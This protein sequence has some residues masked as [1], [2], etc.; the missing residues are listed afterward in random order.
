[1]TKEQVIDVTA[2]LRE[3]N[4][5]QPITV[6]FKGR[7]REVHFFHRGTAEL[8]SDALRGVSEN[9][10]MKR[11]KTRE[12][13][14]LAIVLADLHG[15]SW[16]RFRSL[17]R[18]LWRK[19]LEHSRYSDVEAVALLN[20]ARERIQNGKHLEALGAILLAQMQALIAT[21]TVSREQLSEVL[22]QTTKGE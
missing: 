11:L 7:P 18:W 14:L 2:Q 17:K 13:R 20:A 6:T 16:P 19:R 3:L 21:T 1:M 12:I 22:N 9:E 5:L 10:S 8:F 4:A 15:S